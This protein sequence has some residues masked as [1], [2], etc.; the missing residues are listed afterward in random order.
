MFLALLLPKDLTLKIKT[1]IIKSKIYIYM[2]VCEILTK[3]SKSLSLNIS[4]ILLEDLPSEL[5]F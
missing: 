3:K 4:Q 2:C 5:H 1:R